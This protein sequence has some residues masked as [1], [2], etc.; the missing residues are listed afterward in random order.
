MLSIHSLSLDVVLEPDP[1]Q[2]EEGSGHAPILE[3]PP[4][5]SADLANQRIVDYK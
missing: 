5:Q 2:E 1:S 4:G 3:L